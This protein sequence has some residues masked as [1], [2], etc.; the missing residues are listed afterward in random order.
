MQTGTL[1]RMEF[2]FKFMG[3][4]KGDSFRA[5]AARNENET[6]IVISQWTFPGCPSKQPPVFVLN[7]CQ[8]ASSKPEGKSIEKNLSN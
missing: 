7:L 4:W 2:Y 3:I 8:G 6:V 5:G 1:D